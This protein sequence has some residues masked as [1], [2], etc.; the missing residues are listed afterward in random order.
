[1]SKGQE[2]FSFRTTGKGCDGS[3]RSIDHQDGELHDNKFDYIYLSIPVEVNILKEL[4]KMI[5]EIVPFVKFIASY[6]E[7]TRRMYLQTITKILE[8]YYSDKNLRANPG[9]FLTSFLE[10]ENSELIIPAPRES[11]SVVLDFLNHLSL[12]N[13]FK[14]EKKDTKN[15][16][17]SASLTLNDLKKLYILGAIALKCQKGEEIVCRFITN[18][19]GYIKERRVSPEKELQT[20][21]QLWDSWKKTKKA[22]ISKREDIT[23]SKKA[24]PRKEA[25]SAP[26]SSLPSQHH[27]TI[28]KK[29]KKNNRIENDTIGDVVVIEQEDSQLSSSSSAGALLQALI[30]PLFLGHF[31]EVNVVNASLLE[32][33]VIDSVSSSNVK[34]SS[35]YSSSLELENSESKRS[36]GSASRYEFVMS[37]EES[38]GSQNPWLIPSESS[39]TKRKREGGKDSE[40][41][42]FEV[43]HCLGISDQALEEFLFPK[44]EINS[45]G[46]GMRPS[47][48]RRNY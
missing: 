39:E 45:V 41:K 31:G 27:K 4:Y 32:P 7:C 20:P 13:E 37:L 33:G 23:L 35:S 18:L 19:H 46:L 38:D 22:D 21:E 5:P 11:R 8:N 42:R 10:G 36:S 25:V 16:I 26:S 14:Q 48:A 40:P 29:N 44:S 1:M 3:L 47:G 24:K 34:Q 15:F 12:S 6:S 30:D 43:E 17:V 28:Q 9:A 2:W